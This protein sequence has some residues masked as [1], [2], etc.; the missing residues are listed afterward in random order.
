MFQGPR[1]NGLHG[2]FNCLPKLTHLALGR[3]SWC[4]A[5][6]SKPGL[7]QNKHMVHRTWSLDVRPLTRKTENRIASKAISTRRRH[8]RK[9][10]EELYWYAQW[11]GNGIKMSKELG[12][13]STMTRGQPNAILPGICTDN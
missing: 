12:L 5:N 6:G 3:R 13:R 8:P 11:E 10:S 2:R 7:E 9:L 4:G 1:R